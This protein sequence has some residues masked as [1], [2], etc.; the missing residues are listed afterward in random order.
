VANGISSV[1]SLVR[2][3]LIGVA[4]AGVV[5]VALHAVALFG[6]GDPM[7]GDGGMGFMAIPLPLTFISSVVPGAIAALVYAGA[8]RVTGRPTARFLQVSVAFLLISLAG[9]ATMQGATTLTVI[10]L[11]V[12]HLI[13]G[14]AIMWGVVRGARP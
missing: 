11:E 14:V 6:L 7:A 9:P 12:M 4:V 2:W 3:G 8:E 5:N 13:A 1:G 10:F